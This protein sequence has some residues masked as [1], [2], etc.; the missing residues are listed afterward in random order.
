LRSIIR[1][2]AQGVFGLR[3]VFFFVTFLATMCFRS[4]GGPFIAF[5]VMSG[6]QDAW[7]LRVVGVRLR[8]PLTAR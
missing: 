4:A 7:W 6:V 3:F 5:F 1:T 8:F 2:H